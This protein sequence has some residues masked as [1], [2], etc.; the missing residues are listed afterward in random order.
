MTSDTKQ[1]AGRCKGVVQ[2][3]NE[4]KGYGLIEDKNGKDILVYKS[5]LDFLTLL[6]IGDEIEFEIKDLKE[7]KKAINIKMIKD[8]L[9]SK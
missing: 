3:W 6:D 4:K 8:S 9:F 5:D 1:K 7:G 2:Y